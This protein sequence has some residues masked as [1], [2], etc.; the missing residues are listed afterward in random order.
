M[1][2]YVY[3][4]MLIVILVAIIIY[5]ASTGTG[6]KIIIPTIIFAVIA[7]ALLTKRCRPPKDTVIREE[8]KQKTLQDLIYIHGNPDEVIVTD[9]TRG[10]EIDGVVLAYNKG[11]L[12]NK[13]FLVCNGKV[14]DKK[15]IT[16]ITFNNN[17]GTAFG[18]PDEFQVVLSTNEESRPKIH[19]RAGNDID[20]AKEIVTQLK[21]QLEH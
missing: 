6:T 5:L 9:A 15:S 1:K 18:L 7:C 10:N 2:K 12:D 3:P 14:V 13:G 4:A 21:S 17:Y 20:T 16:D 11:G 8:R 19:I